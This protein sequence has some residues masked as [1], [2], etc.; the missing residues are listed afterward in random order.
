M[1]CIEKQQGRNVLEELIKE[2]ENCDCRIDGISGW[3]C[4]ERQSCYFC[5]NT[6]Y[7]VGGQ[8][9]SRCGYFE[10]VEIYKK[11]KKN[12]KEGC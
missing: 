8:L 10:I 11:E 7:L 9:L 12:G 6:T 2:K 4:A 3:I 1:S 5:G